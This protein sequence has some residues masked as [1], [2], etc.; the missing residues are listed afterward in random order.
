MSEIGNGAYGS[1]LKVRMK[2]GGIL[3]AAKVIKS[4]LVVRDKSGFDKLFAEILVPMKLDHPNLVKLYEVFDFKGKFVLVMEL[5]EGGDLFHNIKKS[6]FIHGSKAGHMVKQI[7][8][9]VNYMH[10]QNVVHR[11]LKPENILIDS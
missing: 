8:S 3:R 6:R 5:C 10:K 7:L 1:V 2:Y 4:T 9:A 11:D